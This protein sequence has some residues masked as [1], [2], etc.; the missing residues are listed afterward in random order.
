MITQ[1][2]CFKKYGDPNKHTGMEVWLVPTDLC[3][4]VIPKKVYCNRDLIPLLSEAFCNIIERGCLI[5]LKTWD[6]CH[7]IRPMRGREKLYNQ[8]MAAKNYAEAVKYLSIHS[9]GMAIDINAASNAFGAEP[10]MHPDLVK[11]FTDAGFDWG[12]LWRKK[13]GMHFQAAKL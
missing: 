7:N 6:G 9:W 13:D 1:S 12:G 10:T 3:K 8:L 4:G 2:Q 5:Y 11:C